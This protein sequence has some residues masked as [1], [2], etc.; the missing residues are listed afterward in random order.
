M[1]AIIHG[2]LP[3]VGFFSFAARCFQL[4]GGGEGGEGGKG[5]GVGFLL[6]QGTLGPFHNDAS[7]FQTIPEHSEALIPTHRLHMS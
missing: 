1:C 3:H 7:S 4:L 5:G 6:K 2:R